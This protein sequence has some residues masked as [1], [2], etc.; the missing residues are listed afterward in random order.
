MKNVFSL[1][2]HIKFKYRNCY[3]TV[4]PIPDYVSDSNFQNVD[5]GVPAFRTESEHQG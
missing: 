5:L 1:Q 4:I 2:S 3:R